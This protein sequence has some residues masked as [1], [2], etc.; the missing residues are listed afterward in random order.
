MAVAHGGANMA[1]L[2]GV[3]GLAEGSLPKLEQDLGCIN[4][5]DFDDRG[6]TLV[7]LLNFSA[8]DPLKAG[9]REPSFERLRR[10][11]EAR[12]EQWGTGGR[13]PTP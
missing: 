10:A 5:V 8:E 12:S 1:L 2:G 9:S 6:K 13:G 11:L 7:R 3:L 4:V